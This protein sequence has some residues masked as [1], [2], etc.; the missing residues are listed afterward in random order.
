[1]ALLDSLK[2]RL[3]IATDDTTQDDLLNE[4]LSDA[5][6]EILDFCN[7]DVLLPR[8][9]SLQ[10][11]LAIIYYNRME[12]EGETSRSEGG[13]S[14]S[15]TTDIPTNIKNRLISYRRLKVVGIANANNQQKDLLS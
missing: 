7:R 10:K 8:M 14:V 11:E 13:V 1:M 12:H 4:L 2:I 9:E 15:Y 6:N 3:S 5:E